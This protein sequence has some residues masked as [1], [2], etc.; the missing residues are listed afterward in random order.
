VVKGPP[1]AG[2]LLVETLG[3]RIPYPY[4][5]GQPPEI[6]GL[7]LESGLQSAG[8]KVLLRPVAAVP[9]RHQDRTSGKPNREPHDGRAQ[10]GHGSPWCAR[11]RSITGQP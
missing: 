6:G 3:E 1:G 9:S 10:V 2:H 4:R 8:A 5:V 7:D 11:A